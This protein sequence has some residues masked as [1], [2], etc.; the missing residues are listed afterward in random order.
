[1]GRKKLSKRLQAVYDMLPSGRFVADVGADHAHLVLE[2]VESGKTPYAQA[3]ENKP[4]PF[5]TMKRNVEASPMGYRIDCSLSD[6]FDR[7]SSDAE[8]V[9]IA[10]MGGRLIIDILRRG[11]KRLAGLDCLVVDAHRDLRY[12]RSEAAKLGLRTQ[13]EELVYEDKV[14]YSVIRFVPG[15]APHY[16]EADLLFGPVIRKRGGEIYLQYLEE[17]RKKVSD[18][19]NKGLDK[20]KRRVYMTLYLLLADELKANRR[21]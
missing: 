14:Y 17:N 9:A 19:L 8:A 21:N 11:Q 10:G 7:L 15:Q 12:L 4:G 18:I 5:M 16:S 13:D 20:E 3:I 1:M 2:L 6:G